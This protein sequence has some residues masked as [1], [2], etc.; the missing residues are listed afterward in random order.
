MDLS[1]PISAVIPSLEGRVLQVLARTDLPLSGS[2]IAS[3]IPTATR[4]GVRRALHRLV[5]AGLVNAEFVPPAM[6]YVA[7]GDHLLWPT[8]AELMSAADRVV[9]LLTQRTL[10]FTATLFPDSSDRERITLALFGSVA[11]SESGPDSDIDVLLIAPDDIDPERIDGLVTT[12]VDGLGAATGNS[13][14]VYALT[15]SRFDELVTERDPLI[16]SWSADAVVFNGPDFRRRL[17]GA[18]WD[19]P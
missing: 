9:H 11:R 1:N 15:R 14:N 6:L 8:I 7:N 17:R 3:L 5:D 10:A 18:S 19:A 4:E 13:A 12:L 2:R 16:P